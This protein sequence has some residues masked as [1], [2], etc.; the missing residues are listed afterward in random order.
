MAAQ[1]LGMDTTKV[2]F[3][4]ATWIT[5]IGGAVVLLYAY[6]LIAGQDGGRGS[7]R[8]ASRRRASRN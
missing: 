5:A 8:W 6:H 7:G 3:N 4:L 1:L 2:I